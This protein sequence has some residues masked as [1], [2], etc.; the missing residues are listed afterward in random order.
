MARRARTGTSEATTRFAT[1]FSTV[2]KKASST[3]SRF[4]VIANITHTGRYRAFVRVAKGLPV[5]SGAS[6]T[7]VLHA[8][9]TPPAK[10]RKK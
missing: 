2:A 5:E 6:S 10:H 3:R 1:Q 9:P 4:S 8:G 7:V